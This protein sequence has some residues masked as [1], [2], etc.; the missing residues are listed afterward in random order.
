MHP[1]FYN[2]VTLNT[3]LQLDTVNAP[4]A[5][6]ANHQTR[7]VQPLHSAQALVGQRNSNLPRFALRKANLFSLI[8]KVFDRFTNAKC[9]VYRN[10]RFVIF[11]A[12]G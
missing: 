12:F 11:P 9:D 1:S 4:N 10:I 2:L 7:F 5:N 8:S 3:I 6:L